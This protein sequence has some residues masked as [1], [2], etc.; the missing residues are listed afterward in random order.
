MGGIAADQLGGRKVYILAQT[1]A[2]ILLI[3]CA[4][5]KNPSVIIICILLSTF[6]TEQ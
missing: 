1:I 5:L 4:F 3:P 6:S 2:G